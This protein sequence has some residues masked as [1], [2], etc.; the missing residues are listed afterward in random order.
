MNK[1][2]VLIGFMGT[3]KTSTGKM[4]SM[5]LGCPFVDLDEYIESKLGMKIKDIFAKHG[6][7]YFRELER[8][9]VSEVSKRRNTVI[10]TGGGTM[11]DSEN[12]TLLRKCGIVIALTADVDSILLRTQKREERPVLDAADKEAGDR[13]EAIKRL[14]DSRKDIYAQADYTIDSS[15]LSPLQVTEE[16]CRILKG[17]MI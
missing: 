9:A 14:L 3:G 16:I 13:R 15:K 5:R 17:E 4:V 6:E 7:A 8:K 1:N 11:K 2:I 12:A 10:S